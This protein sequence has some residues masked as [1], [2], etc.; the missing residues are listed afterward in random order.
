MRISDWSSDVC[1]SD[2]CIK[3]HWDQYALGCESVGRPADRKF[4]RIARDIL[5][6][7]SDSAAADYL[8]EPG[9]SYSYYYQ[10]VSDALKSFNGTA[11]LKADKDMADSDVT[12]QYCLDTLVLSGSPQTVLDKIIDFVDSMR[13]E[14]RR[15]GKEC[16]ST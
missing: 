3:T 5:V 10:F 6:A 15:V 16:V 14:E 8:A 9:N 7:D 1:S 4:W 12:A 11:V 2:L 13:S